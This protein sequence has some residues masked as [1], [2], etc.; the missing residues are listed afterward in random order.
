MG[1][2]IF[3]LPHSQERLSAQKEEMSK[4]CPIYGSQWISVAAYKDLNSNFPDDSWANLAKSR[5]IALQNEGKA[6]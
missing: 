5:V 3:L 2:Y 1:R 6:E 4:N